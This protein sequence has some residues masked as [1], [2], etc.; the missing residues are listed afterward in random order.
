MLKQVRELVWVAFTCVHTCRFKHWALSRKLG[1]SFKETSRKLVRVLSSS[2]KDL[3]VGLP[4]EKQKDSVWEELDADSCELGSA[5]SIMPDMTYEPQSGQNV[6]MGCGYTDSNLYS[7]IMFS[8]INEEEP[9]AVQTSG[10][11]YFSNQSIL[12]CVLLYSCLLTIDVFFS[13]VS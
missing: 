4:D 7:G 11:E 10:S 6:S 8:S 5:G 2:S 13:P 3:S 12:S 1:S 9:L